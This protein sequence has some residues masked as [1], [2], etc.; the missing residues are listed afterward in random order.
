M[1]LQGLVDVLVVFVEPLFFLV[2]EK[3]EIYGTH[4][5]GHEGHRVELEELA[6]GSFFVGDDSYDVLGADAVLTFEVYRRLVGEHH[7]FVDDQGALLHPDLRRFVDAQVMADAVA[8]AVVIHLS[9]GIHRAAG[10]DIQLAAAGSC[11][12]DG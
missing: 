7:T 8:G 11:R 1:G 5:D 10:E 6:V 3:F 12:E 2:G 4:I 9:C